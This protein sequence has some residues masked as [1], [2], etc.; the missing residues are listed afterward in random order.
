MENQIMKPG[1]RLWEI[2]IERLKNVLFSH[3]E[4]QSEKKCKNDFT[5]TRRILQNMAGIDV[6]SSIEYIQSN[7]GDCDCDVLTMI[8]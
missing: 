1:H 8:E 7:Y 4:F 5:F 6:D 2:Y 3:A